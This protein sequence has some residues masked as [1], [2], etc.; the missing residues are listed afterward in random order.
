[1]KTLSVLLWK[2]WKLMTHGYLLHVVAFFVVINGMAV[3]SAWTL[4]SLGVGADHMGALMGT[5][6]WFALYAGGGFILLSMLSPGIAKEKFSG[7]VHNQ[8]AYG[9]RFSEMVFGK[10]LFVTLLSLAELPVLAALFI[11]LQVWGN[12]TSMH[13]FFQMLP[14]AVLVY[15]LLML[16]MSVLVTV[17]N[18]IKPQLSQVASTVAFGLGFIMFSYTQTMVRVLRG[19]PPVVLDVVPVVI[20]CPVIWFSLKLA[21]HLPKSAILKS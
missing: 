20:L 18:Y 2:E 14:A 7:H 10:A 19:V 1:M 6:A 13:P 15:P 16:F 21:D 4:L 8:L 3:Y 5:T 11:L 9:V 12:K 17:V